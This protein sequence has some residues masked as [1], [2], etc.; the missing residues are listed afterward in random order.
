M[1][2]VLLTL[3]LVLTVSVRGQDPARGGPGRL[4]V[5]LL[6][7]VPTERALASGIR[8]RLGGRQ[9][10]EYTTSARLTDRD[11]VIVLHGQDASD[12]APARLVIA[13]QGS[14]SSGPRSAV[15]GRVSLAVAP[16]QVRRVMTRMLTRSDRILSLGARR[17]GLRPADR[18]ALRRGDYDA[19]FVPD[20]HDREL[21]AE[22]AIRFATENGV[23]SVTTAPWLAR[24]SSAVGVIPDLDAAVIAIV[25]LLQRP[26]TG[27]IRVPSIT[28]VHVAA[29]RDVGLSPR[30]VRLAWAHRIYG[31]AAGEPR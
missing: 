19:L 25:G 22:S 12:L 2:R 8:A 14:P 10:L 26:R 1:T 6:D 7:T 3:A 15:L 4:F 24:S 27:T 23:P 21:T 13:A 28:T 17:P 16:G 20:L 18:E 30:P 11:T 5:R 9:L 29:W 31:T